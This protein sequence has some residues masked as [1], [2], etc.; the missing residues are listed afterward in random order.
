MGICEKKVKNMEEKRTM[1]TIEQACK[2]CISCINK[3]VVVVGGGP[4]GI[5]A[6][7]GAVKA[8]EI[9]YLSNTGVVLAGCGL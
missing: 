3:D 2:E 1:K 8:G 7:V 4:A 6:A 5:G 9:Y